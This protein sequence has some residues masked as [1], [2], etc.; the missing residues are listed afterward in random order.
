MRVFLFVL[1]RPQ[2]T[3][4]EKFVISGLSAKL[5]DFS[6][7]SHK[8]THSGYKLPVVAALNAFDL[9]GSG[10]TLPQGVWAVNKESGERK[11]YIVKW[12]NA[13]RMSPTSCGFELLGAW[14][15]RELEVPA[16]TPAAV[17]VSPDFVQTA[18]QKRPA[19]DAALQSIGLNFGSEYLPGLLPFPA[20][21]PLNPSLEQQISQLYVFDIFIGNSDRGHQK[22]N[23]GLIN[24]GLFA[25]DHELAFSFMREL[26]FLRN[27]NP[28][29]L[30]ETDSFWYEKHHFYQKIRTMQPDLSQ[31][32]NRLSRFDNEFWDKAY[33][34][35]PDPWRTPEV[36][37]IKAYLNLITENLDKFALSIQQTLNQ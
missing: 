17:E 32:V 21:L 4:R 24:S 18:M 36:L 29:I 25:Y 27:S 11:Q 37:G 14:M 23:V 33:S 16:I 26:P 9:P 34:L 20:E 13:N 19:F 28:W 35:I 22:P 1:L 12:Q 6:M 31:Y 2:T 3:R 7:H 10:S 30:R 8:L 5:P 15:A